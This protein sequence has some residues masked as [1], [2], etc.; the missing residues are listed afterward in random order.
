[1]SIEWASSGVRINAVAP[2]IIYSPTAKANYKENIF[3]AVLPY[4]PPKRFGTPQEVN[5]FHKLAY[6]FL[7]VSSL[8]VSGSMLSFV[9]GSFV[10]H[11]SNTEGGRSQQLVRANLAH[12]RKE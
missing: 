10:H 12:R 6:I 1:M 5:N 7:K 3:E 9:A 8:G 11:R 2:G 4:L